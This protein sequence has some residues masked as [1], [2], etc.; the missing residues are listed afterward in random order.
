MEGGERY[1]DSI[2][3]GWP[4][5]RACGGNPCCGLI[6]LLLISSIASPQSFSSSTEEYT[7]KHIT[8]YQCIN[9]CEDALEENEGN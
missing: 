5:K 7:R 4:N 6:N 2:S 8:C 9:L 3:R 1:L